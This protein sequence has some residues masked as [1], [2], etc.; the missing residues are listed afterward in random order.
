[1][2][3]DKLQRVKLKDLNPAPYN[4]NEM[5]VTERRLLKQSLKHYGYI[6]NIVVNKDLT[7]I[8]GH[9]RVEELIEDGT[10]EEDVVVL[11]LSKDEEKALNLALRRIKGKADP[12]LELKIIEDLSL[13]GFD[14]ELAGFDDIKLQELSTEIKPE[15]KEVK[16]DDF[17]PESVT[18][19]VCKKGDIWQLGRHRL[20]C[21]DATKI[22]D[23]QWLMDGNKAD[24]VFTDPPY[25]FEDDSYFNNLLEYTKNDACIFIMHGEKPLARLIVKFEDMFKR[26]YAVDFRMAKFMANNRPMYRADFIA[27][28]NRGKARFKNLRDAF[29]NFLSIAKLKGKSAHYQH[30]KSVRLPAEF[31]RHFS[32]ED[33]IILDLFGGSGSTLIAADQ[34]NR[35]CYLMELTEK[36]CDIIIKR[37]E[38][39][40]GVT[41][42]KIS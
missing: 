17:D 28:F 5:D 33:E 22:G 41:G 11:D 36:N 20:L 2:L 19:T 37:Y 38:E 32:S 40:S 4:P 6:E 26:L 15:K 23:V 34:L 25:D 42:K 30:E 35:T 29:S 27:E 12:E 7:I 39:H 9:H 14:V 18:E 21:G 24:M 3:K 8:D 10:L 13:K 16:E 31:M 1:M